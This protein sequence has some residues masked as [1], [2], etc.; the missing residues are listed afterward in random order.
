VLAWLEGTQFSTWVRGDSLWG[1][2]FVLTLHVL[3]TAVVIGFVFIISLRLLGLFETIRY[4]SLNRLFPV[5]WA[6][7]VLQFLSGFAL[8]MTKPTRYVADAAFVLKF[9]LVI[10]GIALAL[11]FYATLKREGAAWDAAGG[12]PARGV[13]YVAASLLVWCGVLIAA[14]LTAHLGALYTG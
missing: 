6:A 5:V 9:S 13:K 12:S 7:L 8:W 1:W 10:V 3:G 2:P 14:R 4:S 11:Y